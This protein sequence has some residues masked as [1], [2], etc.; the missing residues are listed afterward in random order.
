ML[1]NFKDH[2][3]FS[4]FTENSNI[5]FRNILSLIKLI[6]L[7]F[8]NIKS[9][10]FAFN[11]II[12]FG[13]L[14]IISRNIYNWKTIRRIRY[15]VIECVWLISISIKLIKLCFIFLKYLKIKSIN[16]LSRV[17]IKYLIKH[18]SVK[19]LTFS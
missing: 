6:N 8:T 17:N 1:I 4:I 16:N 9:I 15:Y 10:V 19:L 18:S 12:F 13:W 14:F 11:A 7:K 5:Q 3:A 2:I